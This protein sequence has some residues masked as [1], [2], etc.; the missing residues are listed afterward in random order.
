MTNQLDFEI[1]QHEIGP[2]HISVVCGVMDREHHLRASLPTWLAYPG[3]GQVVIVDWSSRVPIVPPDDPRV[4]VVRVEGQKH[5][6]PA[7]CHNLGLRLATGDRILRLDADH[8]LKR[9]FFNKHPLIARSY[10]YSVDQTKLDGLDEIHLA[11]VVYAWR[12]NLLT[13]GG[14]NERIVTYGWEDN[15][16]VERMSAWGFAS[17]TINIDTLHHIPHD[18][19]SRVANQNI[20]HL[21][22]ERPKLFS[23]AWNL[24]VL[25]RSVAANREAARNR[26][27]SPEMGDVMTSFSINEMAPRLFLCKEIV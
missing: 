11:G 22:G 1:L 18:D 24:G 8:Q 17:T 16:L 5:W 6:C 20:S 3:V 14:Y 10:F 4:I 21:E 25:H 7:K 26:P 23:W 27:W 19:E 9:G 2:A 13:I 15:D 12:E